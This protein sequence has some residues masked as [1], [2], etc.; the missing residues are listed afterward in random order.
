MQYFTD[1]VLRAMF[2]RAGFEVTRFD[3]IKDGHDYGY[4][5]IPTT[6]REAS[7]PGRTNVPAD[8]PLRLT[9]RIAAGRARL[10]A[11]DG[12][13]AL[14]GACAY[15]QAFMGLYP[16]LC[17]APFILDDTES[18]DGHEA[19]SRLGRLAVRKPTP[20]ILAGLRHVV[21]SA[22]LHDGAIAARLA[23][24]GYSGDVLSLRSDGLAG[25]ADHPPS[26]FA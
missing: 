2:A 12:P 20:E 6:P 14:Y 4:H 9:A 22:W 3:S 5:L 23:S 10:A 8:L 19:Y 17:S 1:A 7:W 13:V 26:L 24:L 11:L 15:A 25:T 21:V 16:D 18:Y